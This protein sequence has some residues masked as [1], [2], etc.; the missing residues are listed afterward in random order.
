MKAS[1]PSTDLQRIRL[2][3][4]SSV[5]FKDLPAGTL[6]RLAQL[7]TSA[8]LEDGDVVHG[9]WQPVDKLWLVLSGALR[10]VLLSEDGS[11][12]T[13]AV[14]GAG[15]FY[16]AASFVKD[17]ISPA[18]AYAIGRTEAAVF[19]MDRLQREFANDKAVKAHVKRLIYR[20]LNA[21]VSAYRDAL[22]VPLPRRLARRLLS[23]ALA[24]GHDSETAVI[25]LRVSQDDLAAMLG[26][27]RSKV[28][29]ELRKLES[30]GAVQ[31]GYRSVVVR[32]LDRL[33][34][35]AGPGVVPY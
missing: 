17:E 21:I 4:G 12:F 8:L 33:R 31:R 20:R 27:S 7:G 9:G 26:A 2:S 16:G 5:H 24:S 29:A 19:D 35:A 28:N 34:E 13:A 6:D 22:T 25:E 30:A 11:A 1:L 14:I 32:D 23:Q 18:E 15:S 3:L 10:L